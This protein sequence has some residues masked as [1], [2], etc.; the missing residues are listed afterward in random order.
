MVIVKNNPQI[1]FDLI[2]E[3]PSIAA[4]ERDFVIS[5]DQITH[6]RFF[7]VIT[8]QPTM[9]CYPCNGASMPKSSRKAATAAADLSY[10]RRYSAANRAH[11]DKLRRAL[12]QTDPNDRTAPDAVTREAAVLVPIIERDGDLN[13]V[14][15]R[16]SDIV[17]SHRGQVA[18]PG[19]R[20]DPVDTT[21]LDTALREAREEVG[22]ER[23]IVDVLGGFPTMSTVSSGMRVAPFVAVLTQSVD[24]KIDPIE[25]AEVFEVPLKVLSDA[26]YRGLYEWRRDKDRPSSNFPAIFYSGQTIWGL[27]LRITESLLEIMEIPRPKKHP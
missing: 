4:L 26:R 18:F 21:L 16:R 11:I 17:E 15:I 25:V 13:I 6:F 14:F 10:S 2:D 12:H 1:A 8:P 27:T 23:H 19:G 20:V 22:I 9:L 5:P 3:A 7:G 24:Y